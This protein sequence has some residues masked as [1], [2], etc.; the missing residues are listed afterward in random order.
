MLV[1]DFKSVRMPPQDL[2]KR[3]LWRHYGGCDPVVQG[4][5]VPD[6]VTMVE[7]IHGLLPARSKQQLRHFQSKIVQL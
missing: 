4:Q 2:V 3:S 6:L 5:V 7:A 1:S